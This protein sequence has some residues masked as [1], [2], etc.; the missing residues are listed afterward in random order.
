MV[1]NVA[2]PA[3]NARRCW[4]KEGGFDHSDP[5]KDLCLA[6]ECC[7]ASIPIVHQQLI[8]L[9]IMAAH[10]EIQ[11]TVTIHVAHLD[12]PSARAAP[13]EAAPP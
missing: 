2:L 1:L 7:L 9:A 12:R 10:R 13:C 5:D 11:V 6:S 8:C 3:S 4:L